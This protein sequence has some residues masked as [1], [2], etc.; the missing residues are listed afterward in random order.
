VAITHADDVANV[1]VDPG[2]MQQVLINL[3]VNARDA[4]PSG[5]SL[6]IHCANE[7]LSAGDAQWLEGPEPVPAGDYVVI[8]VSDTGTGMSAETLSHAFEPFFST[9]PQ[10]KGTG[11]GLSTVYGIV[12][13][14]GGYVSVTTRPGSGTAVSVYLPRHDQ[15]APPAQAAACAACRVS[16]AETVLLVEDEDSV[17]SLVRRVLQRQ[18]YTVLEASNGAEALRIAERHR[19]T[20][21]LLV[22][23]MMMPGMSGTVLAEQ[24]TRRRPGARVLF[25]SGYTDDQFPTLGPGKELLL[26]PFEPAELARRARTVLD[27]RPATV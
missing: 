8:T 11:L 16:G 19:G 1:R 15:P 18:G 14:S 27:G 9:K 25:M 21:P 10:G 4:M 7:T 22:T 3:A 2:Q 12:R 13:Q 26:K 5:G 20:I 6:S 17:R 24:F 23:D